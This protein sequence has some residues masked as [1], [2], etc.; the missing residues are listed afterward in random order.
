[1]STN[2]ETDIFRHDTIADTNL[3]TVAIC[4]VCR[5]CHALLHTTTT[6]CFS[7]SVY[8]CGPAY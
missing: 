5:A 2:T 6:S 8:M 1:M 7:V 3:P 4:Y